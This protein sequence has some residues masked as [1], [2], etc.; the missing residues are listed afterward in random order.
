MSVAGKLKS[1]IRDCSDGA[2]F[3]FTEDVRNNKL[4]QVT[5]DNYTTCI[6]RI[7]ANAHICVTLCDNVDFCNG[8][9]QPPNDTE[10][11]CNETDNATCAAWALGFGPGPLGPMADRL[12]GRAYL[13]P[14]VAAILCV[15]VFG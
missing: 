12:L 1:F 5:A 9:R 2:N 7:S 14:L 10:T 3:S 11:E 13:L 4:G 6:Y 8:P 15:Q